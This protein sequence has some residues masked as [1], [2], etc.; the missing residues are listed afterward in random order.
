MRSALILALAGGAVA[1]TGLIGEP[2]KS[3]P[4]REFM[5]QKLEHAQRVL[6][7]ITLEDFELVTKNARKLSALSQEAAWRAF[8]S[9]EYIEHS[10]RFR[11]NTEALAR[12]AANRNLDG[13]TLAHFNVTMSCVECHKFVRGKSAAR[14]KG[15]VGG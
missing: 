8:D 11:R 5:R 1:I 13:A 6:E 10:A 15:R 4:N 9:P 7:G 14:I 3:S 12:A 2:Q